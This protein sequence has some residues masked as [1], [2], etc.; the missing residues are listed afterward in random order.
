MGKKFECDSVSFFEFLHN[1][2]SLKQYGLDSNTAMTAIFP[3][4]YTFFWN[5]NASRIFKKLWTSHQNFWTPEKVEAA[6]KHG[7]S[8]VNAYILAS[9]IE[10]ET[11]KDEDKSKI[12]SVYLNRLHAG[13][14]LSA[15]PTIKY[16][17]R[18]FEL[19]RV[20]EKYLQVESPYNTYKYPGC[21]RVRFALP[22]TNTRSC[23]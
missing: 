21:H 10:E 15:D 17:L 4:T 5:T 13:M 8:P 2:D 18:N 22:P 7:L 16:A 11:N 6:H 20:Y 23:A 3:D 19:K 12:A 9:I 1:K 14:K